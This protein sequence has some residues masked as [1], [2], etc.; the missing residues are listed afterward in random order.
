VTCSVSI[1]ISGYFQSIWRPPSAGLNY[2]GFQSSGGVH[3]SVGDF[4]STEIER[5]IEDSVT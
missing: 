3:H 4:R 2:L 5:D 1:Y